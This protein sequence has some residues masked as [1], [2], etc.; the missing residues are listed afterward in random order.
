MNKFLSQIYRNNAYKATVLK[1]VSFI[2]YAWNDALSKLLTTNSQMPLSAH[3]VIFYQYVFAAC[4]LIPCYGTSFRKTQKTLIYPGYHLLRAILCTLGTVMLN[5][6]F[7]VMPLS[8]AVGFNL[9]SPFI[10]IVCAYLL[11]QEKLSLKKAVALL[12][13][14]IAYLVLLDSRHYQQTT[15]SLQQCLMPTIALLC[16]QANT[17]VT[18]KLTQEKET[19]INLTLFLCIAMPLLL[20]PFEG[21]Q[22][23]KLSQEQI[24]ILLQ[25]AINGTLAIMAL[26]QAIACVELTFLL[27]FGFLKYSIVS[28][29]G[30]LY[31]LEVPNSIHTIGISISMLALFYLNHQAKENKSQLNPLQSSKSI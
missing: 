28:F 13:S 24:I 1:I 30:Y 4:L 15:I 26:H 20:L 21:M 14:I 8:Y 29:F 12:I 9:L 18:K 3:S 22:F 25:M 7:T 27:P 10:T 17:L 23:E 5:Q 16:F 19:N 31:F 11:F 6:S 2:L